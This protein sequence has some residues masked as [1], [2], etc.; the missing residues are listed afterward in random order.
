MRSCLLVAGNH[1]W[2]AKESFKNEEPPAG[3]GFVF[4]IDVSSIRLLILPVFVFSTSSVLDLA[5]D[6][7]HLASC[8]YNWRAVVVYYTCS[9]LCSQMPKRV[10]NN[11]IHHRAKTLLSVFYSSFLQVHFHMGLLS[12]SY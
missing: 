12:L 11:Q 2:V 8:D 9:L 10:Q 5:A 7:L 1:P 6:V 4:H 3:I